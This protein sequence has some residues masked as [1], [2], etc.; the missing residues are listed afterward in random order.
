MLAYVRVNRIRQIMVQGVVG[1]RKK[2]RRMKY[3]EIFHMLG[4]AMGQ[5][6]DNRKDHGGDT[7]H[8]SPY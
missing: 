7:N 4:Q 8:G 3:G 5:D 1:K 6:H 2:K